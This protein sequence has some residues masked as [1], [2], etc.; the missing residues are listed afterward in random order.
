MHLELLLS[1]GMFPIKTVGAPGAQGAV[2]TGTHGIGVSTPSAAAVA[3]ATAGLEGVL[4]MPKVGMFTIGLKSMMLAAGGPPAI[5][6]FAGSTTSAL[7]ATPKLHA[8]IA[9]ATTC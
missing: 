6:L 2:V 5:V 7:G 4:H 8:I 9:P 1:A 3:E